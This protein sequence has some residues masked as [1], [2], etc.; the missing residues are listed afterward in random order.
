MK[1]DEL[2]KYYNV[3]SECWKL[4]RKYSGPVEDDEFWDSLLEDAKLIM[5]KYE[6][7][8]AIVGATIEE[9]EKV[10]RETRNAK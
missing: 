1:E 10:Y 3:Y 5:G 7:G 8:S 2:R 6:V 9:I 4:F